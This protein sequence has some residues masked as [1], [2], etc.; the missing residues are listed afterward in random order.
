ML[1][2][3]SALDARPAVGTGDRGMAAQAAPLTAPQGV[4]VVLVDVS[5]L[6]FPVGTAGQAA[7]CL[8]SL[9]V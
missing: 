8:P 1:V 9:S 6:V 4:V 3:D 5:V 7:R 2:S